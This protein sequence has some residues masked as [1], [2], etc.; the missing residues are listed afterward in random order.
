MTN[1]LTGTVR[2]MFASEQDKTVTRNIKEGGLTLDIPL[3][4]HLIKLPGEGYASF[5][6][7]G[8]I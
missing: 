7:E 6:D 5:A 3:L 4:D 1:P 8:L 2:N